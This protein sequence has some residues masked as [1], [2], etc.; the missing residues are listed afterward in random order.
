MIGT[1]L[2]AGSNTKLNKLSKYS[3]VRSTAV[4]ITVQ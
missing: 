4:I 2:Y 3:T 1:Y